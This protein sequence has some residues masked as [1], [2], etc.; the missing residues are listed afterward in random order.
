MK[1][2]IAAMVL[3][4]VAGAA[5]A[6][7]RPSV[8]LPDSV[9]RPEM[10]TFTLDNGLEVTILPFG[11]VPKVSVFLAID[12]GNLDEK[13]S[14]VWLADL[15]GKLLE[16]GT[17]ELDAAA[18]ARTAAEW[19]GEINIGVGADTLSV[20]GTALSDRAGDFV[21][22]VA[23]IVETPRLPESELPRLKADLLRQLA[24][25]RSEPQQIATA[26]LRSLLYPGQTYGRYFPTEAMLK[27]YTIEQVKAYLATYVHA[28]RA[29]LYVAGKLDATAVEQAAR[30]AFGDWRG[31]KPVR[32]RAARPR[33][34][35]A[36]HFVERTGAVQS[37]LRL[38]LPVVTP[39]HPDYVPLQVTNHLLGGYFSSRVTS[40]IREQKGYTYSPNSQL[41]AR[42]GAV[43]WVQN[44]DV[45]TNVTGEAIKE[46][47]KEIARLR[48]E[49]PSAKELDDVKANIVGTF[50]IGQSTRQGRIAYRRMIDLHGLPKDFDLVAE[51][52]KVTPEMVKAMAGKYLDPRRMTMVVV[53][54]GKQVQSQL[55]GIARVIQ[56]KPVP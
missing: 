35:R 18:L 41:A 22:L 31:G 29:H 3:A 49:A 32:A 40:N 21:G 43:Y 19:G 30:E 9:P 7:E 11:D 52:Q 28:G 24:V 26:K 27:G 54:D 8:T 39:D 14:E 5:S 1:K 4:A 6:S 53:G 56:S 20:G 36:I 2:M 17:T 10:R 51:A 15:A 12:T 25:A 16:Q 47:E 33:T 23:K 50:L 13:P 34:A 37:T 42:Q 44:A 48:A 46:I 55:K 38:A 45:T